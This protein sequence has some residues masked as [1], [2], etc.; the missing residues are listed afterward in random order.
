MSKQNFAGKYSRY[1]QAIALFKKH[2][3]MRT[4]QILQAGIHPATLYSMRDSGMLETISRGVFRL[5][6]TPP[7]SNPDLTIVSARVPSGVIC[8]ISALS[9]HDLTT[10]I[11]HQVQLALPR[12][13]EEPRIK[14]PP[15]KTYRFAAQ[16]FTEGVETHRIDGIPVRVYSPEKTL[17]DCVKF[18]RE[19]GTE[20]IIEALKFY[21]ERK[22]IHIDLI[23]HYSSICRVSNMIRPYLEAILQ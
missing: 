13:A 6:N 21:R 4:K 1:D 8:L 17:A 10:Q 12:G 5:A 16:A 18:R 11:P 14:H 2:G 22:P 15:I 23:L 20:T 9:F 7:L 3:I 19:I